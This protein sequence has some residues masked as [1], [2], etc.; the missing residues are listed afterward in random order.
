[1]E[2][3]KCVCHS[4]GMCHYIVLNPLQEGRVLLSVRMFQFRNK[5]KESDEIQEEMK[6]VIH[7]GFLYLM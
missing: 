2:L 6:G 4:A 5:L 7:I 3:V 1:M